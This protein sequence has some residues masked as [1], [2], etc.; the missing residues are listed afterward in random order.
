MIENPQREP[1]LGMSDN[2]GLFFTF[3]C[4]TSKSHRAEY[5]VL[6]NK[7]D[8]HSMNEMIS[9]IQW[10]SS[11]AIGM[12]MSNGIPLLIRLTCLLIS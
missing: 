4:Y 2:V 5:K 10:E 7:G 3:I 6:W 11:Y 12:L 9:N 1:P 8:Y